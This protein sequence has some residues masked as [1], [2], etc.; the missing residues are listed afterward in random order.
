MATACSSVYDVMGPSSGKL[1]RR[2][3]CGCRVATDMGMGGQ[4]LMK[5]KEKPTWT[6]E[7]SVELQLK[8]IDGVTPDKSGG[9]FQHTGEVLPW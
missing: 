8:L 6:A 5:T 3:R 1:F 4:T 7:Q 9:Y 2:L